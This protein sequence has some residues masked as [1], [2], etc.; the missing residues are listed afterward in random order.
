[1]ALNYSDCSP[2]WSGK[3]LYGVKLL[4]TH[5]KRDPGEFSEGTMKNNE[6]SLKNYFMNTNQIVISH[7]E[8]QFEHGLCFI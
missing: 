6:V 5:N 3:H 7:V 2:C 8:A 1:M 4:G